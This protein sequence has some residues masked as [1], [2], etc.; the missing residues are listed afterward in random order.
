MLYISLVQ[1]CCI[2][3]VQFCS[4]DTAKQSVGILGLCICGTFVKNYL[5]GTRTIEHPPP[6]LP[7]NR[8]QMILQKSLYLFKLNS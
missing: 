8:L 6:I 7:L 2:Q 3:L 4:C 5:L 1:F